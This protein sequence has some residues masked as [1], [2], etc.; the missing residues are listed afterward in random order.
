V[1]NPSSRSRSTSRRRDSNSKC[2]LRVSNDGSPDSVTAFRGDMD[3]D[4]FN[5]QT[6]K[7]WGCG[8]LRASARNRAISLSDKPTGTGATLVERAARKIDGGARPSLLL[9]LQ[10]LKAAAPPKFPSPGL[11]RKSSDRKVTRLSLG[12]HPLNQLTR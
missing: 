3:P 4:I 8:E 9:S 1:T 5:A 10:L 11:S 7:L 12:Q 2:S 6:R